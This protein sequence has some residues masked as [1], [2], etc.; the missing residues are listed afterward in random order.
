MVIEPLGC[1]KAKAAAKISDLHAKL[2]S[3]ERKYAEADAN[4]FC[5][6]THQ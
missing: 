2:H 4:C 5:N 6:K 3:V 1:D